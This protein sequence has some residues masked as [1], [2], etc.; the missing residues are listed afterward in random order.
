MVTRKFIVKH[1][2]NK[3]KMDLHLKLNITAHLKSLHCVMLSSEAA[4]LHEM[5]QKHPM[6]HEAAVDNKNCSS[7]RLIYHET[8]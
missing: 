7:I 5:K 2:R 3:I 1:L 6:Q 8:L 4:G